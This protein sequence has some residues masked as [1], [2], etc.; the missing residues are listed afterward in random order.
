MYFLHIVLQFYENKK[1]NIG[2]LSEKYYPGSDIRDEPYYELFSEIQNHFIEKP[3][4]GCYVCLCNKGFYHSMPSGFPGYNESGNKC[5]NCGKEIG[6][7]R[8]EIME[9]DNKL[10]TVY[11]IVKREDYL[12]IFKDENDIEKTKQSARE[13]FYKINYM[14]LKQFE[15]SKMNKLY[16]R[17]KGLPTNIDKNYYLR[18][19]KVIRNLSQVSY[20]LLNYILYSHLF[21]AKIFTKNDR[22]DKYKPKDKDKEMSWGEIINE[23]FCS[24]PLQC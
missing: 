6:T 22:F 23:S 5:Q 14:T 19:N 17:E 13:N 8:K 3:N 18:D 10:N 16:E 4:E 7:I 24:S 15:E 9:E 11:E 12:R 2:Y 1:G 21:F 20:R